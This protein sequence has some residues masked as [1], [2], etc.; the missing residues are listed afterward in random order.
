MGKGKRRKLVD[1]GP[2]E[3]WHRNHGHPAYRLMK[4]NGANGWVVVRFDGACQ[5]NGRTDAIGGFGWTISWVGTGRKADEGNGVCQGDVVTNNVAEW[6]GL[7]AGL[8]GVADMVAKSTIHWTRPDGVLIEGDSTL[9]VKCLSGK[10]RCKVRRLAHARDE[11][12]RLLA[13]LG[14]P[15]HI[16]WIGRESNAECDRLAAATLTCGTVG[17]SN[18][19]GSDDG[20]AQAERRMAVN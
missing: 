6:N 16:R 8:R 4:T 11:A 19:D 12:L 7:L 18:E 17:P 15:W 14:L 5:G 2:D 20:D 10:W 1:D 13:E 3:P 9:V